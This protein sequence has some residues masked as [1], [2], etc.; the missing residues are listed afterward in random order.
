MDS[1][2]V[3]DDGLYSAV[4]QPPCKHARPVTLPSA[5]PRNRIASSPSTK[6]PQNLPPER[7]PQ[8]P[9]KKTVLSPSTHIQ[10]STTSLAAISHLSF[11]WL[12][13]RRR[14]DQHPEVPVCLSRGRPW[15]TE[16]VVFTA[17]LLQWKCETTCLTR[18]PSGL[19]IGQVFLLV[20]EVNFQSLVYNGRI[21]GGA[22]LS[23]LG[24]V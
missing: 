10:Y 1:P 12:V 5:H 24:P 7:I 8:P 6:K 22:C 11:T 18:P 14:K 16:R 9:N 3:V 23:V 15:R 2:R 20:V 4:T 21:S 17:D 19:E 13:L